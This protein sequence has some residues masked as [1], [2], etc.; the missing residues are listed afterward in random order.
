MELLGSTNW[1]EK[2]KWIG[3]VCKRLMLKGPVKEPRKQE[4]R[5]D[6]TLH[7]QASRV[8]KTYMTITFSLPE[9][10]VGLLSSQEQQQ[11][12]QNQQNHSTPPAS[13]CGLHVSG[14]LAVVHPP[15]FHFRV[16]ILTSDLTVFYFCFFFLFLVGPLLQQPDKFG[17]FNAALRRTHSKLFGNASV[18]GR[19]FVFQTH[20]GRRK[21]E[22]SGTT[23]T[24]QLDTQNGRWWGRH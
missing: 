8:G 18:E 7:S 9:P 14:I 21:K 20:V 12:Q 4:L 16:Y 19:G 6:R 24:K 23:P 22:K 15:I 3:E 17:I 11:A 5:F 10:D 2:T 13:E 1:G